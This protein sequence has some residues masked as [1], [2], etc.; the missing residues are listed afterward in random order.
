MT[1]NFSYQKWVPALFAL[2]VI[3]L[4]VQIGSTPIYILDEAKNAQ[5]AREMWYSQNWLVPTFNGELR[6]DKPP[7]HYWF[8][9]VAY[10]VFGVGAGSARFFSALMGIFTLWISYLWAKKWLGPEVGFF[11]LLSL[12]LS[13]HF[14]FEFRLSVPDPYLI[15]FTAASLMAGFNYL[16]D[17]KNNVLWLFITASSLGIA[18]LAK[19]PVALGLPGLVFLG[20]VIWQKKWWVFKDWKIIPAGALALGIGLPWYI[21][22][23][24]VTDG[25]F[26]EGFFFEHNFS[27]F[28]S[29]ME[30]HG[31][32]FILTPLIVLIGMLPFSLLVFN[33]LQPKRG[34]FKVPV[35]VF[36]FCTVLVFVAFFSISSTKLPNYAMP[37]Y[38]FVALLIAMFLKKVFT[39]ETPLPKYFIPVMVL[40]SVALPL[41]AYLGIRA[42]NAVSDLWW[43]ACLLLVLPVGTIF[44]YVLSIKDKLAGMGAV[45]VSWALFSVI[46]IQIGYPLLYNRNPVSYIKSLLAPDRVMFGYKAYNPAFNFNVQP[47]GVPVKVFEKIEDLQKA[48]LL[49]QT[50]SPAEKNTGIYILSRKEHLEELMPLKVTL[51]AEKRDLF[52][53]PTT[54]ILKVKK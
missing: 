47:D 6:T 23:H 5:C 30:G 1:N 43:V 7:L 4:F 49:L 53:L 15:F 36:A 17:S 2:A 13:V 14:I 27:R 21:M 28:S 16:Q 25:A 26:T 40:L 39:G 11:T 10:Q 33:S 37:C 19:G 35:F 3:L 54:V 9:G 48:I 32:P 18:M 44:G 8:M 34:F 41:T 31:G 46:F 51:L 50:K 52:E 42:E 29:E 20:F 38:P 45:L 22:I 24:K 12:V